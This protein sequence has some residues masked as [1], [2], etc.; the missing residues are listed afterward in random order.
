MPLMEQ[1]SPPARRFGPDFVQAQRHRYANKPPEQR[2]LTYDIAVL[3][4]FAPWRDWLD[5]QLTLLPQA[6]AD[7][8][9]GRLWLD[10]H[11]WTVMIELATGA[12]LRAASLNVA[13]ER[14]WDGL[15]PDWTILSDTGE[16]LCF[17]EVHVDNP[18][19]ATYGQMHAWYG[20][21]ERIKRIPVPVVLTLASTGRPIAPPDPHTAKKI[22]QALRGELMRPWRQPYFTT[23]GYTFL[24]QAEP[25]GGGTM[26]S[27]LGLHACLVPPSSIA[28]VVSARQL[29]D[30]VQD[31]VRKYRGPAEAFDVPL[32]VAVDAHRFTGVGVEQLDQLLAGSLTTT[33]QFNLGDTWIGEGTVDLGR[34]ERWEMPP[35]PAG[36]LWVHNRMPF[37]LTW[38]PNPGARR[39]APA[40]LGSVFG[41]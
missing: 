7:A 10:E 31:K 9:A 4:E 26:S 23:Q 39:P 14:E 2:P 25:R 13:Y 35:D 3:E 6:D 16:P 40:T 24:V 41:S 1:V 17:V 12:G 22:A 20:L 18:S 28:G 38:R 34:P 5:K 8:L 15:T 32:V 21:V 11:F 37:D 29:A 19:P 27:P 33:L 30:R 36:V